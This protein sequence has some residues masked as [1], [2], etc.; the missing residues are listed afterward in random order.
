MIATAI[1]K[2]RLEEEKL[3]LESELSS[4][5]V[6]NPSNPGD[7]EAAPKESINE[8]DPLD[9]ASEIEDFSD[10]RAILNDLEIRYNSVL[11]ALV[12]IEKGTYGVCEISGE[13]IEK[14]RLEADPSAKTCIK[15]MR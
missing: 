13:P 15:H 2:K 10:N 3:K 1:F 8:A 11:D 7:W 12:R 9:T 14:G 5:G 6:K 4:V